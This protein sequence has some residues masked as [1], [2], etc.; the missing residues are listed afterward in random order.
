MAVS[1]RELLVYIAS[2]IPVHG[3]FVLM[4]EVLC[5][6]YDSLITSSLDE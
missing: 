2:V 6:W 1:L 5:A 3:P 4:K